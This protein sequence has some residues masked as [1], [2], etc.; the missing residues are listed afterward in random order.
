M[1]PTATGPPRHANRRATPACATLTPGTAGSTTAPLT[2][3][4]CANN[5]AIRGITLNHPTIS[6]C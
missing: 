1:N 2:Q 5:P 3:N 6:R 4:P